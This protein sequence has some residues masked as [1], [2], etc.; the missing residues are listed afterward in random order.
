MTQEHLKKTSKARNVDSMLQVQ[1]EEDK[2]QQYKTEL[3]GVKWSVN[4]AT[5]G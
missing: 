1:V 4:Y 2:R 5:L 3:D